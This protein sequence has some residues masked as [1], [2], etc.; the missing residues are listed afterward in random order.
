MF[1]LHT[2]WT[3]LLGFGLLLVSAPLA[4]T[5][6]TEI[7]VGLVLDDGGQALPGVDGSGTSARPSSGQ[8]PPATS[9]SPS[10]CVTSS[11]AVAAAV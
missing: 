3:L 7:L 2:S 5:T 11:R 1:R 8:R 4:A 6:E 9:C 10:A